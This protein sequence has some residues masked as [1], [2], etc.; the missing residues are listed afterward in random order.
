LVGIFCLLG[1]FGRSPS[2]RNVSKNLTGKFEKNFL[3]FPETAKISLPKYQ[4]FGFFSNILNVKVNLFYAIGEISSSATED[5][6]T[7]FLV[8][9]VREL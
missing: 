2:Q 7:D 6:F 3:S 5:V 4:K 1:S 8:K 9:S